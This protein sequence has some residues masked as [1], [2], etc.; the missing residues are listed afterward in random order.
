MMNRVRGGE[1]VVPGCAVLRTQPSRAT[2][3]HLLLALALAGCSSRAGSTTDSAAARAGGADRAA[4][5]SASVDTAGVRPATRDSTAAGTTASGEILLPFRAR[6]NEPGWSLDVG[7][8]EMTLVADYGERKVV[9]PTP[10]PTRSGDTTRWAT[11]AQ[12]HDVVVTVVDRLC[13]DGMSGFPFPRT[14]TVRLDG[15]EL[16]GCAG[17]TVDVLV[18]PAWTVRE[19][20]GAALPEDAPPTLEFA[21]NGRVAGRAPCN[22]FT[23]SY[24]L[25]GDE[26]SF[27]QLAMTRMACAPPLMERE[28]TFVALLGAVRRFERTGDSLIL[29]TDDGRA[30]TARR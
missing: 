9:A 19:I 28:R 5:P 16:A 12:G 24:T 13:H 23:G 22:R 1:W 26:L 25:R 7:P 3:R 6:G 4:A 10:A 29:R 21:A 18:G 17:E 11:R 2:T 30:I 14:V 8:K 20:D 15:R 27:S